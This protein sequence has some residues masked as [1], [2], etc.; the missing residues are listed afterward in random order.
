MNS[1]GK[2]AVAWVAA[3]IVVAGIAGG[4][5]YLYRQNARAETVAAVC[6]ETRAFAATLDPTVPISEGSERVVVL[7]DSYAMGWQ[8]GG[9]THAWPQTFG[10]AS[11]VAVYVNAF[12]GSGV[13]G[14]TYCTDQVYSARV[15]AVNALGP[16]AVI[17]QTGLNDVSASA[18]TI[19]NAVRSLVAAL[20]AERVLVVGPPPAPARERADLERVDTALATSARAA[21]IDYLSLLNVA[22]PYAD[23]LLHATEAGQ[24]IIGATVANAW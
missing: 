18:E 7:G 11:G 5:A 23:D 20:H 10:N 16:D 8:I 6:E 12:G 15:D 22:V 4:G 21:G 17:I 1:R 3:L 19:E 2:R 14:S 13:T 9:P 24:Q